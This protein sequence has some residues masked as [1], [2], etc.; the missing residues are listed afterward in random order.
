MGVEGLA[1]SWSIAYIVATVVALRAMR[2]RLQR[3]EGRAIVQ[4]FVRV[5]IAWLVATVIGYDTAVRAIAA[6]TTAL[7]LGGTAFLLALRAMHVK[8]LTDLTSA[9][10]RRPVAA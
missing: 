7:A 4:T 3:L 9:I 1:L 8:E 5:G 6:T 2:Q 10:R